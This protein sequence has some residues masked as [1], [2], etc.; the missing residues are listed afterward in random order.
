MADH[1]RPMEELLQVPILGIKDVIV[2][3]AVLANEFELKIELLDFISNNPFFG[4]DNDDPISHLKRFNQITRTFKINQVLHDVE[5]DVKNTQEALTIIENKAKSTPLTPPPKTPS[6]SVPKPKEN[7][8]LNPHQLLIPYP[9]RLQ[10]D[11]FQALENPTGRAYHFIY[12]IDIVD[13]L[14]DK[15]PIENNS[16]SGNP[17]PS[18][19]I[20][21]V[22]LSL[23]LTSCGDSDFLLEETDTLPSHSNLSLPSYESF[24]FDTDHQEEKSSDSTTSQSDH[25]LP[26][27]EASCFDVDYQKEKSSG[28]TTSHSDISSLEY[29]SFHFDQLPPADRSDLYHKEFVDELAHII[30]PSQYDHFYIDLED[31]PRE[32]TRLL[33]ENISDTSTKVITIHELNDL[34]VL[35]SNYDSTFSKEFYEIDLLVSFPSRNK[36]INFVPRIFIIKGFQS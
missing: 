22:S 5:S 19:D 8:K 25:S 36:D 4:L 33:K 15:F 34:C 3:P 17:T 21:V 27:Y 24:C 14:C 12:R 9:S 18:F 31:D 7:P 35:L 16:L 29:E 26:D 6:L 30:S 28:S 1:L 10:K 11:K 13:S 20:V 23:S 2:V 32:L